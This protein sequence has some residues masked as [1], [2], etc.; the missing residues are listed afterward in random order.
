MLGKNS[1]KRGI[2]RS[3]NQGI[4][5]SADEENRERCLLEG[6]D[7]LLRNRRNDRPK[8]TTGGV[9]SYFKEHE[10]SLLQADKEGGFV[11]MSTS[12]FQEKTSS[13]NMKNFESTTV[14]A[15]K[16]AL[17]KNGHQQRHQGND[18]KE[19]A[20]SPATP[21]LSENSGEGIDSNLSSFS[22]DD[23]VEPIKLKVAQKLIW[24]VFG[25]G[26]IA[27][28]TMAGKFEH[29]HCMNISKSESLVRIEGAM[30]HVL[31]IRP[32]Y[33]L[34]LNSPS[35]PVREPPSL[36]A[37]HFGKRRHVQGRSPL[38]LSVFVAIMV[39]LSIGFALTVI[40]TKRSARRAQ[41][42]KLLQEAR[43]LLSDP[44]TN[45]PK[46]TG[47]HDRLSASNNELSKVNDALEEHLVD[48]ELEGKHVVAAEY[49]DKAISILAEGRCKIDGFRHGDSTAAAAPQNAKPSPSDVPTAIGPIWHANI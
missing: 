16:G 49:N 2:S 1:K 26:V 28:P 37:V 13:A 24:L 8:L 41:N 33:V 4:S 6:A 17:N 29:F 25:F 18:P 44:T 23:S 22:G 11:G 32:V 10:L 48:E 19:R 46:L 9:V 5:R 14:K 40:F 12:S 3:L 31:N 20:A 42:T 21:P 38:L 36:D 43:S 35:P 39:A 34:E 30:R 15:S 7:S 27:V 45:K 47:I